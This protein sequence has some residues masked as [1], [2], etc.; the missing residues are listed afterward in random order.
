[1]TIES[2]TADPANRPGRYRR[3]G[4]LVALAVVIA[5]VAAA[6]SPTPN[7]F[8]IA[9]GGTIPL[10]TIQTDTTPVIV[11]DVLGCQL[12]YTPPGVSIVGASATVP[13]VN[14]EW[15]G[16]ITVPNV[17]VNLPAIT[18]VLPA[19]SICGNTGAGIPINLPPLS[20]VATGQLNLATSQLVLKGVVI[21]THID[22]FGMVIPIDIPLDT[23]TVQL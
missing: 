22:L 1:M 3:R 2:T 9:L 16:V 19:L 14:V 20:V 11:G 6:C 18:A 17:K 7:G 8:D 5:T 15:T 23:I 10:P 13:G 4:P 21:S 12:G